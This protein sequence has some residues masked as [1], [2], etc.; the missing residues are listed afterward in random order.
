MG[1]R[2]KICIYLICLL[3]SS[4]FLLF[5]RLLM[6]SLPEGMMSKDATSTLKVV[7]DLW[8]RA[9]VPDTV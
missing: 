5:W 1:S 4:I 6:T 9:M 8:K 7:W 2:L 3:A